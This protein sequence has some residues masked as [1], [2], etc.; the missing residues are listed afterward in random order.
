MSRIRHGYA[1]I[2]PI[3]APYFTTGTTDDMRGVML[4]YGTPPSSGIGLVWYGM[5]TSGGMIGLINAL[6]AGVLV[7]VIGLML[8]ATTLVTLVAA[9]IGTVVTYATIQ[10]L[11]G[12][13]FERRGRDLP[14]LFP[15]DEAD[16]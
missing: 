9:V 2:A 5:T 14:T 12:G 3:V 10:L 16:Q 6:V 15:S 8:G 7:G 13:Y 11:T 1:E 4:S